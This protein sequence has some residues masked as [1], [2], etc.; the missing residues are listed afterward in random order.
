MEKLPSKERQR[1]QQILIELENSGNAA[2]AI[3]RQIDI[4]SSSIAEISMT[5][6]TIKGVESLKQDS[7]ILVPIGSD[8]FIRAKVIETDKVLTGLGADVAAKREAKDAIDMLE[9]Q[10]K[11]FEESIERARGELEKLNKRIEELKPKAE[12]L[13][14]RAREE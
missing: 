2:E 4:L 1:L 5:T 11:E 8:S 6:K 10:K 9:G 12:Q 14:A 3:R 7:E 13:L